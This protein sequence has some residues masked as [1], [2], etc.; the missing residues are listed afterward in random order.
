MLRSIVLLLLGGLSGVAV[1]HGGA[2]PPPVTPEAAPATLHYLGDCLSA[3]FPTRHDKI[4]RRA[5]LRHAGAR[6]ADRHCRFRAKLARESGLRTDAKSASRAEGIGQQIP[7]AEE[8]CKR[9]GG[10]TGTRGEARF[11]A[12]CAAWLDARNLRWQTEPRTDDCRIRNAELSYVS[13]PGHVR[14]GQ[15]AGRRKLGLVALCPNDGILAGMR[16]ILRPDAYREAAGYSPRIDE[17]EREMV[18]R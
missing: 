1:G 3:G 10:L 16:T 9:K 18:P 12:A 8:D 14:Q 11:G 7:E 17:L 15:R 4:I 13:G 5:W 6:Y 2:A